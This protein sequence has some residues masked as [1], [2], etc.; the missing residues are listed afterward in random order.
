M[1]IKELIL[2]L[3]AIQA[4][5]F[6]S[7]TLKSGAQSPIYI[8]LR[9][10]VSY[11]RILKQVSALLWEKIQPL[12]FDLICGVPYTALPIATCLS[13]HYDLP[14]VLRRK[15]AKD[16]GMK[17]MIEGAFEKDQTCL[18][19]EDVITSG[20]SIMETTEPL[21]QEGLKVCDVAVVLDRQQGGRQNLE[22]QGFR[23]H[24]L[25]TLSELLNTLQQEGKIDAEIVHAIL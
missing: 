21:F 22:H 7:F 15:E 6:G 9:L 23:V 13:V 17:K 4:I 10:I 19:I 5:K 8:D 2:D 18:I 14:M 25:F 11:P 1:S 3:H 16:H 20:K 24:A 12:S